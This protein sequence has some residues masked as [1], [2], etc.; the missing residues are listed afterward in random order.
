MIAALYVVITFSLAAISFGAIQVRPAEA[1]NHLASYNKRYIFAV[2][3]GCVIAN[4]FSPLGIV[5]V[6]V[7]GGSTLGMLLAIYFVS[8]RLSNET[9][10]LV[11]NTLIACLFMFPI[12]IE[13]H[14]VSNLPIIGT[15]ISLAIS[16]AISMVVGGL[17]IKAVAR[18]VDLYQ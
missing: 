17:L 6:F 12:A 14:F 11:A 10:K 1:F 13:L 16:E 18:K 9:T 2:T 15:F 8:K 7:G 4:V 5:D 3:M